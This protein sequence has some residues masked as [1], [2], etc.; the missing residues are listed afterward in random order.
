MIKKKNTS[1][2]KKIVFLSRNTHSKNKTKQF[3][4]DAFFIGVKNCFA[5]KLKLI[6]HFS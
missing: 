3:Y 5:Y 6:N 1:G 2:E 4:P